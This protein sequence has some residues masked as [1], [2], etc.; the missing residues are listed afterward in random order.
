MLYLSDKYP[1][2]V[3]YAAHTHADQ[4]RKGT[5][6]PYISHPIAVS[7]LVVE[8]GGNEVQAIAALLHDVLEDCGAHHAPVIAARFGNDVLTIV[9]GLTDG[10]PDDQGIKP[11]WR[12]RK[13]SYLAHLMSADLEI[14]LVS[15]CDKLHN[16]IAIADDH[17][18]IGD[19]I[20]DR[21]SQPKSGTIW[22]YNE[23][24]KVLT[25]RLGAC[26]RLLWKLDAALKRWVC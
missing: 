21:F 10:L 18:L 4:V 22:Y 15:A 19:A 13:E 26:H 16:A 6:I 14:V 5:E 23:L 24:A 3:A 1:E 11:P 25:V 2:A 9:E 8:H 17:S 12:E 20:F 7:A